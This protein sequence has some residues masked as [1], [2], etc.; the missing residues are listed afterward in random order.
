MSV[1][2][3]ERLLAQMIVADR[4]R[5]R[6]LLGFHK[7]GRWA[8][9]YTGFLDEVRS[10][11]DPANAAIRIAQEQAGIVPGPAEHRATFVFSSN[12]WGVARELEFLAESY[13]GE[14]A[15]SRNIRPEWFALDAIP[16]ARMP[17]DDALWYPAFL[18]GKKM[19]GHFDFA[20]DGRKL[21][22]HTLEELDIDEDP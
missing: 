10:G 4:A 16:F 14:P 3:E 12:A 1:T 11:E 21:L 22:A 2:N 5:G 18:D 20:P 6:V 15:E 17:A 19:R 8:G 9:F 13:A 7:S